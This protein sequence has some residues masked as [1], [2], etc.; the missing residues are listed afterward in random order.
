MISTIAAI[1]IVVVCCAVM[2]VLDGVLHFP[3]FAKSAVKIALFVPAP[4]VRLHFAL[5]NR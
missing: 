3:Y 4:V 1:A 5:K 2:A